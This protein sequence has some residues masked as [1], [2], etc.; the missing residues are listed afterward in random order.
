MKNN[1]SSIFNKTN[2]P[3]AAIL[4]SGD[5]VSLSE[6]SLCFA[7]L[8][9]CPNNGED[10]CIICKKI[11]HKNHAD[12]LI[13]PQEKENISVEEMLQVV[14]ESYTLPYESQAKVF[15]LNNFEKTTALA[16]NKLLK[17]LEE[18]PQNVYFVICVKN[19]MAVLPTIMSRCQKFYLQK[20]DEQ[21]ILDAIKDYDLTESQKQDV[22]G[23]CGGAIQEAKNFCEKENFFEIV[24]FCFDLFQNYTSSSKAVLYAKTLY[25]LKDDFRLFLKIYNNILSDVL[26]TKL[27][28]VSEVKNKNRIN[29]YQKIS[30]NYSYR[31]LCEI[32]K[33]LNEINERLM[34]NCNQSII[35]DNF[36]M[37]ILEEKTKWQ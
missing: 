12:V 25:G 17:T 15:I 10:E 21:S 28:L 29:E 35:V 18:P 1:F 30:E 14:E 6:A 31:A 5:D 26:N 9:H 34:R 13:Y 32:A 20:Y 7:K 2:L 19:E 22:V 3:H 37:K 24:D 16:Q 4:I 11:E 23:F 33:Y 36:L 8:V 27:K